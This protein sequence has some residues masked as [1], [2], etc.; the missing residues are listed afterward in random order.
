MSKS[1]IIAQ[2][3]ERF[4]A[5]RPQYDRAHVEE[6]AARCETRGIPWCSE[7]VDWHGPDEPHTSDD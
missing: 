6:I 3:V 2:F 4:L 7:C 5:R 1:E